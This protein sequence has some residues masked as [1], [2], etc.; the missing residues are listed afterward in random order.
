MLDPGVEVMPGNHVQ[1]GDCIVY[2]HKPLH[3]V[4]GETVGFP[5]MLGVFNHF[6]YADIQPVLGM[7]V[8]TPHDNCM[9]KQNGE[10][11]QRLVTVEEAFTLYQVENDT[12][13]QKLNQAKQ[14]LINIGQS[15]VLEM[16]LIY[17]Y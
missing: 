4:L 15:H 16:Q 7:L 5:Q 2:E 10:L 9:F 13:V 11:P 12:C 3:K 14:Y 17:Q 6:A 8:S 1:W